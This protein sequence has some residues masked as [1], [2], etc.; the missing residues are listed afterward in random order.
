ME[1]VKT[2]D[3]VFDAY[4]EDIGV[5]VATGG[6]DYF[7]VQKGWAIFG[8]KQRVVPLSAVASCQGCQGGQVRLNLPKNSLQKI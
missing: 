5:V 7:I 3:T 4:G 6:G 2:G 1:P 8:G